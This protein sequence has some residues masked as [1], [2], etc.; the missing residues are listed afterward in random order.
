[1]PVI[2]WAFTMSGWPEFSLCPKAIAAVLES[3][4]IAKA[5][6]TAPETVNAIVFNQNRPA[7]ISPRRDH[8]LT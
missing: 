8:E 3:A 1:M 7:C 4:A 2:V 5:N 6:S